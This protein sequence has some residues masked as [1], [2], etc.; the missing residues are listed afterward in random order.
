MNVNNHIEAASSDGVQTIRFNRPDKKNAITAQM[1]QALADAIDT[2]N[3]DDNIRCILFLGQP[4][5]FTA[6]NDI[7]DFAQIAM[8]GGKRSSMAVFE[9]LE[10]MIMAKKPMV[11]GV[12]GLAIGVGTTML[13]H[14]DH[15]I[16]STV[17]S[18]RTPFVDLGLIPEAGSSLFAPRLMGHHKAFWLL[19][20]GAKFSSDQAKEAGFVNQIFR[21]EELETRAIEIAQSIAA[22]PP[23]AL[24]ISRKLI[25]GD[26]SDILARM[27]EEAEIFGQRLQSDEAKQAFM[28]FMSR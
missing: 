11:A 13:M 27:R 17:A 10:R 2:A 3:G 28:A 6:G 18:F 1:Y 25:R 15:V 22:K 26:R 4:G 20:M 19:A 23:V 9:F 7:A 12:D 24:E 8:S 5:A 21:S 14:C 16:A